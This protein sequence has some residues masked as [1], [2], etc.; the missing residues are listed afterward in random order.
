MT[1]SLAQQP[2]VAPSVPEPRSFT[3]YGDVLAAAQD[4]WDARSLWL[5]GV[6]EALGDET[7]HQ[8]E[9]RY[10]SL[11]ATWQEGISASRLPVCQRG[12]EHGLSLL[13]SELLWSALSL[14]LE[15][16]RSGPTTIDLLNHISI[17]PRDRLTAFPLLTPEAPLAKGGFVILA[18][19]TEY[20]S[21]TMEVLPESAILDEVL[22]SRV[23]DT[24]FWNLNDES[25]LYDTLRPLYR[26]LDKSANAYV[27]YHQNNFADSSF[28]RRSARIRHEWLKL[29][30]TLKRHP[31][32][33]WNRPEVQSLSEREVR[34]LF[35]LAATALDILPENHDIFTGRGLVS[36]LVRRLNAGDGYLGLLRPTSRLVREQWVRPASEET[37]H[38]PG[39]DQGIAV[40]RFELDDRAYEI[41]KLE[42]NS[43]QTVAGVELR[44]P[45][46]TLDQLALSRD[47]DQSIRLT[48]TH[49]RAGQG[50][51]QEWGL[52]DRIQYGLHPVL[53]FYGPPGTGKTA[54]AEALAHE[55]GRPL[56]VADYSKI[57]N[58]YF[59]VTEKN[60]VRVFNDA[61]R[62]KA[63]LLWDEADAMMFDRDDAKQ[64][65]EVRDVNVIL[66]RIERFEG[67]C[68]LAT[69]RRHRLDKALTRRI[70]MQVEFRRPTTKSERLRIWQA[71]LPPQL[72]LDD[73]VDLD[74]L[75]EEDLSGGE[76][77]NVM[78]NAARFAAARGV[79]DTR[80][81]AVDF[82]DAVRWETRSRQQH[83]REIGFCRASLR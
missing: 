33:S 29:T 57:Q 38:G 9:M 56:M 76:I 63:V 54:A 53:L 59:G 5:Q 78:L 72:P 18:N 67:V 55:L 60:I 31:T 44:E 42:R 52:A 15:A 22:G 25:E 58:C 64:P 71:M 35:T 39:C 27:A 68:I 49:A 65:S 16:T 8:R 46:I 32:W 12:V 73:T 80:L 82:A 74:A 36:T 41:L 19:D 50:L 79:A 81:T 2:P 62:R 23:M 10:R 6:K 37:R 66:Q 69:N 17:E 24:G 61:Q 1:P 83:E 7:L 43:R 48:V 45:R 20:E 21:M 47:I 26:M 4:M 75:A 3:S 28:H 13:E 70:S 51:L 34:I 11:R 14:G 40:T 77:K 30:E